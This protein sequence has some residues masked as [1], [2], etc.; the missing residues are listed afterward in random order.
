MH[1]YYDVEE[2]DKDKDED[3]RSETNL[4][5]RASTYV[6]MQAS[7]QTGG[8]EQRRSCPE[9]QSERFLPRDG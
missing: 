7:S 1:H 4:N 8:M 2:K 9:S 5:K 6:R 3:D